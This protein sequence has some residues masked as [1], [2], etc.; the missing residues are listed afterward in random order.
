MYIHLRTHY[1]TAAYIILFTRR[2]LLGFEVF[3]CKMTRY[4][5]TRNITLYRRLQTTSM[6]RV[7]IRHVV[8]IIK[9]F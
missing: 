2:L 5:S 8:C 4:I 9:G 7:A 3:V 1:I 6:C